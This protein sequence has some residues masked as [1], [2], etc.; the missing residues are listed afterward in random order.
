MVNSNELRW[1]GLELDWCGEGFSPYSDGRS[2]CY[3]S[4]LKGG[5][6]LIHSPSDDNSFRDFDRLQD[7][8][9]VISS[10]LDFY[11]RDWLGAAASGAIWTDYSSKDVPMMRAKLEKELIMKTPDG[12]HF[13]WLTEPKPYVSDVT[14]AF[15]R[16]DI[17]DLLTS[18]EGDLSTALFSGIRVYGELH[19]RGLIL[20]GSDNDLK[21]KRVQWEKT[22]LNSYDAQLGHFLRTGE[23]KEAIDKLTYGVQ[24]FCGVD[25]TR[26]RRLL[27]YD[28]AAFQQN[29]ERIAVLYYKN[30]VSALQNDLEQLKQ[31][32]KGTS[33]RA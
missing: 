32:L 21:L 6:C 25:Q 28:G 10:L 22:A 27:T 1:V 11:E 17:A 14:S 12:R 4:G 15:L 30:D 23:G 8:S 2:L 31:E 18:S 5:Y 20:Q 29:L 26:L 16:K 13:V 33:K 24:I 9:I 19:K 7:G 3:S